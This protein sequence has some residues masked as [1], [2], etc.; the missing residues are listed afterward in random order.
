M[1]TGV[2][3]IGGEIAQRRHPDLHVCSLRLPGPDDGGAGVASREAGS[4][5]GCGP[6]R[7]PECGPTADPRTQS[8]DPRTADPKQHPVARE[9]PRQ[10]PPHTI[11]LWKDPGWGDGAAGGGQASSSL[12]VLCHEMPEN[13]APKVRRVLPGKPRPAPASSPR[14]CKHQERTP[15]VSQDAWK[16]DTVSGRHGRAGSA[17]GKNRCRRR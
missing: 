1:G 11:A 7:G 2:S 9:M 6:P 15:H 5:G 13:V 3:G 4:V 10:A 16:S 17:K 14:R 8:A 12:L